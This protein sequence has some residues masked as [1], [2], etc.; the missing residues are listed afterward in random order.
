MVNVSG[1]GRGRIYIYIF[2]SPVSRSLCIGVEQD[3]RKAEP[4]QAAGDSPAWLALPFASRAVTC[5]FGCAAPLLPV[6]GP[7]GPGA[8][9]SGLSGPRPPLPVV[10]VRVCAFGIGSWAVGAV[11]PSFQRGQSVKRSKVHSSSD[12]GTDERV[13][14]G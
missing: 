10:P 6:Y 9:L 4:E 2:F 8:A 14:T 12:G 11:I 3:E 1:E 13:S 5:P 7:A